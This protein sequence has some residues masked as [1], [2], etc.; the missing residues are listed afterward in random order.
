M[1]ACARSAVCWPWH[2]APRPAGE[3]PGEVEAKDL[4][5][6]LG[7]VV[8]G[9][10]ARRLADD[11]SRCLRARQGQRDRIGRLG[12]LGGFRRAT[13]ARGRAAR[14]LVEPR[15]RRGR[16]RCLD[17]GGHRGLGELSAAR[18]RLV[19]TGAGALPGRSFVGLDIRQ[20]DCRL[21]A[22]PA[23]RC[24]NRGQRRLEL[25]ARRH[26]KRGIVGEEGVHPFELFLVTL[27]ELHLELDEPLDDPAAGDGV[28]L[29]EAELDHRVACLEMSLSPKLADRHELDKGGVAALL[30]DER[31]S[32]RRRPVAR[33]GRPVCRAL[34]LLA[35]MEARTVG[36]TRG[37]LD[38]DRRALRGL[39][40]PAGEA[41]PGH[42][43]VGG[44]E[45]AILELE[46][47]E[48]VGE[49]IAIARG[50]L[51]KAVLELDLDGSG[52]GG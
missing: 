17:L 41:G 20:G 40:Q 12:C 24:A 49:K 10:D 28:D 26:D 21:S 3:H 22:P 25:G 30:E 16:G 2:S 48:L 4:P 36:P 29:V 38:R 31:P 52:S 47:R 46:A 19:D 1:V 51:A 43:A 7:N 5:A 45:I 23:A 8:V 6:G 35:S 44:V 32:I 34:E 27:D 39:A 18:D 42:G 50:L 33:A 9:K 11:E 37:R 15:V 14:R 13:R